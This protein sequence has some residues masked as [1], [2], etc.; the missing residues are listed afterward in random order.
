MSVPPRCRRAAL[1]LRSM[2]GS[3]SLI[4]VLDLLQPASRSR[5]RIHCDREAV[6]EHALQFGERVFKGC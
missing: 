5:G 3:V 6:V 2:S 4:D 1:K